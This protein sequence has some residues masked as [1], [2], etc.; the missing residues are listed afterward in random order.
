MCITTF[1]WQSHSACSL[2]VGF[3]HAQWGRSTCILHFS[4]GCVPTTSHCSDDVQG[5]VLLSGDYCAFSCAVPR[6]GAGASGA[7]LRRLG[8]W[9]FRDRDRPLSI[10]CRPDPRPALHPNWPSRNY[11]PVRARKR[12]TKQSYRTCFMKG[13]DCNCS[14][15]NVRMAGSN[16][17]WHRWELTWFSTLYRG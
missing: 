16:H 13:D 9:R 14:N 11:P 4:R 6:P 12:S 8:D 1:C 3:A 17:A 5:S 15:D 2:F 10:R 7:P